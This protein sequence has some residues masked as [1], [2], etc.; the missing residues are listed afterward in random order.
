MLKGSSRYGGPPI[1]EI[2][3]LLAIG[4]RYD[5]RNPLKNGSEAPKN[6]NQ[7]DNDR[8]ES[9]R[10]VARFDVFAD[11]YRQTYSRTSPAAE[12]LVGTPAQTSSSEGM[13][14]SI[15]GAM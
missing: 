4:V 8:E 5:K 6:G 15:S 13:R 1:A 7:R 2:G 12:R 11:R 10:F 14:V 9:K 3:D